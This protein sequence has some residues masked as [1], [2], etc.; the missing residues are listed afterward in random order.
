MNSKSLNLTLLVARDEVEPP[1]PAFSGLHDNVF[2]MTWN[3]RTT[4]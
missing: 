2:T 1:K 3:A 4:P